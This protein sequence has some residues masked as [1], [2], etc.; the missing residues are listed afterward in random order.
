MKKSILAI[1]VLAAMIVGC[2]KDDNDLSRKDM[3]VGTWTL[4][5]YG[6]D[7]NNNS[8]VDLGETAPVSDSFI[9]AKFTFNGNGSAT[10]VSSF[11]GMKDT[12]NGQWALVNNDNSIRMIESN[13]TSY[14]DIKS[15]TGNTLT[16]RDT[17]DATPNTA[18]WYVMTK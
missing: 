6:L 17:T 1:A 11:L 10:L 3:L 5:Q 18:T 14:M 15:I 16:L 2:K 12:A 13:D 7:A 4:S 9:T 8:V